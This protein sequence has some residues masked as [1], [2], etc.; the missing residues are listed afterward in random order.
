MMMRSATRNPQRQIPSASPTNGSALP[1]SSAFSLTAPMAAAPIFPTAIPPAIQARTTARPAAIYFTGC[2]LSAG[3]GDATVLSVEFCAS[4][5]CDSVVCDADAALSCANIPVIA[6]IPINAITASIFL[7]ISIPLPMQFIFVRP[8]A[9]YFAAHSLPYDRLNQM[10][11]RQPLPS[12]T[13]SVRLCLSLILKCERLKFPARLVEEL[14]E[15]F[16][17]LQ[18][19]DLNCDYHSLEHDDDQV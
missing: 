3:A 14:A 10:I 2:E 5:V 8:K 12:G 7:F 6:T 16:I 17:I 9:F 11:P 1:E 13:P 19:Y 18:S 15:E 4:V